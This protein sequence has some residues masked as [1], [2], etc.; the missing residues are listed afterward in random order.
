LPGSGGLTAI[1]KH[2]RAISS[3]AGSPV[4]ELQATRPESGDA[5]MRKPDYRYPDTGPAQL[6]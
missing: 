1:T 4:F 5:A 3:P 2:Y 6:L